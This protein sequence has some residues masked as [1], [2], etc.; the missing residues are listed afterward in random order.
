M[1]STASNVGQSEGSGPASKYMCGLVIHATNHSP[2][3]KGMKKNPPTTAFQKR[4]RL[5]CKHRTC[6]LLL[7]I[8]VNTTSTGTQLE[9]KVVMTSVEVYRAP[10]YRH[11]IPEAKIVYFCGEENY[12]DCW[13]KMADFCLH[14]M[15][16]LE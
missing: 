15:V 13:R 12:N 8:K 3:K 14:K 9:K 7:S 4:M 5:S 6:S 1:T 2:G 11:C 16:C 10:R